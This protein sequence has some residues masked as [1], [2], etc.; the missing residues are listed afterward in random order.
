[1]T[2]HSHY[3]FV[4]LTAMAILVPAETIEATQPTDLDQGPNFILDYGSWPDVNAWI[5]ES[6][7]VIELSNASIIIEVKSTDGDAGD[8]YS[9]RSG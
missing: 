8:S 4:I 9:R 6:K 5:K 1:M 2:R 3:L 7:T